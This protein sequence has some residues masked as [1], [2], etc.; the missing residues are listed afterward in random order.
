MTTAQPLIQA[1]GL[2]KR[3]GGFTAVDAIDVAVRAG[4]AFG[5]LGPNGAG[6]SSTM[7]MIGCVSP[8]SGGEL[9]ILGMDPVHDGPAIRAR[10]G[11][12]PQLDTLDPELT[13]RE[14]L[15]TY[16]RYFGI[17]RRVA[18][19]RAAELL[20]FVQLGERADSKVEPLS[21]G[22]KRRL[23]IARALVNEPDIVL[24]DEPTT[25]LDP[26]ARH[27][28]W[29]RLFQLKQQGVTLVLTTHYMDEA[30]QLCDRLV[31]MDGGR[32][33]AEGSPRVLI[34]Q[35]ST[36]EVVELRFAAESQEP[37]AGKLEELGERIEVLPDRILIYVP[38]GD[39]AVAEVTA[40]GLSP[41][42]VLV[43]RSSLE[44]VFLHLT[45]RT[46]VD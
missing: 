38:D 27:L 8:P 9:R 17:T 33:V 20:D 42:N 15:I 12:C 46:L 39:A 16:A 43:R 22:M 40:L 36:R 23:T 44:D 41:A 26:Q 18:R 2:V 11:V 24:L 29:E 5:F 3:F 25:G 1:R 31:V 34:E 45:G 4:E 6:K 30:E 13:V 10:L 32:I 35:H 21:G 14:N 28:V 37:F 7:R 19:H